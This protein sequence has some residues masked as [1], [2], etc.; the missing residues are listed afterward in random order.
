MQGLL[1]VAQG[2][3]GTAAVAQPDEGGLNGPER[4]HQVFKGSKTDLLVPPG[5]LGALVAGVGAAPRPAAAPPWAS[6]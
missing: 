4:V 3:A 5:E 1:V 2:L 6:P